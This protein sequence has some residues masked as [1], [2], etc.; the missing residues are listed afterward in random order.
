[1]EDYNVA[2]ML[3]DGFKGIVLD[4]R[5]LINEDGIIF[6]CIIDDFVYIGNARKCKNPTVKLRIGGR[7][8]QRRVANLV[9]TVFCNDNEPLN[10]KQKVSFLDLDTTNIH[11]SNLEVSLHTAKRIKKDESIEHGD[12]HWIN[13]DSG[14]YC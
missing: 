6:D 5:Y 1:M 7:D 8:V 12:F 11:A 10:R 9:A 13:G 3:E 2:Q 14:I 4:A